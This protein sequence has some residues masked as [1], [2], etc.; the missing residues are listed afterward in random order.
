MHRVVGEARVQQALGE[1]WRLGDAP[2]VYPGESKEI[3]A[4]FTYENRV[5]PASNVQTPAA[6]TDYSMNTASDGSGTDITADFTVVVQVFGE[7]AKYTVTNNGASLGYVTLLR[8]RGQAIDAPSAN[9]IVEGTGERVFRFEPRWL[10][11]TNL[12]EQIALYLLD[13]LSALN[14]FPVVQVEARPEKQFKPDLT[15][16]VSLDIPRLGIEEDFRLGYVE[17]ET[18][19]ETCQ[20]VRTKMVYEPFVELLEY[21]KFPTQIGVSSRFGI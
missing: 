20:A 21:W 17:H 7:R 12:G 19:S 13:L 5:V 10:Q 3:W 4:E 15:Q 11:S 6:G 16:R 2:P 9:F 8:T 14:A 18:L 1:L